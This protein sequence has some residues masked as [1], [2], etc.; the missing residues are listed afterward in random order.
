MYTNLMKSNIIMR[1]ILKAAIC[2]IL[3]TI[4]CMI[5]YCKNTSFVTIM[6]VS[7]LIISFF[8]M[9]LHSCYVDVYYMYKAHDEFIAS[10][11]DGDGVL[12][13]TLP[14]GFKTEIQTLCALPCDNNDKIYLKYDETDKMYPFK[15]L[16][17]TTAGEKL[18]SL[19]AESV[20][21]LILWYLTP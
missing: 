7:G 16:E 15:V 17:K 9:W 2:I 20:S 10:L 12:M 14:L 8:I 13:D 18:F 6:I 1:R 21:P 11:S 5:A 3:I 19:S 4:I